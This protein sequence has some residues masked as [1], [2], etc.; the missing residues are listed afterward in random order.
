MDDFLPMR[1]AAG[2][3]NSATDAQYEINQRDWLIA[4]LIIAS[5]GGAIRVPEAVLCG[6]WQFVVTCEYDS[7]TGDTVFRATPKNAGGVIADK[8]AK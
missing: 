3:R 1:D 6:A 4:A 5:T 2:E 8:P 7:D